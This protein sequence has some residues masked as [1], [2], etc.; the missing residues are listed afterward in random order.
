[1]LPGIIE[2]RTPRCCVCNKSSVIKVDGDRYREWQ[3]GTYVQTA[4]PEMRD[5]DRELLVSG[6]H[7]ECW[8]LLGDD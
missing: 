3:R 2:V 5:D 7:P 4:F 6:T 8:A 1:M